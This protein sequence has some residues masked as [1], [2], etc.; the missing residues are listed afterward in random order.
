MHTH[1]TMNTKS[2]LAFSA[3][4]VAL[5]MI[6]SPLL[7]AANANAFSISQFIG[8]SQSSSQSGQCVSGVAVATSCTNT[9]TN[10]NFNTGNQV[11]GTQ[12]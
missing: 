2:I 3:V 12:R 11:A 5:A 8:L 6:A 1:D 10:T 7:T 9:A 4:A